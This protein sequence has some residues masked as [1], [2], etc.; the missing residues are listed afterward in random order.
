MMQPVNVTRP[1]GY[2]GHVGVPHGVSLDGEQWLF[3]HVHLHDG[4]GPVRQ[5]RPELIELG[6]QGKISP[7]NP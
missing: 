3:A 5:Y 1:G 2:L 4:P 7:R 6:L